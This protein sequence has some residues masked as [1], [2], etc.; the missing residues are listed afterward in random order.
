MIIVVLIEAFIE[1]IKDN[2]YAKKNN[3]YDKNIF[4]RSSD[5]YYSDFDCDI[6]LKKPKNYKEND[7][8][9]QGEQA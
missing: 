6:I 5:W 4:L 3:K 8:D 2:L 7:K 1:T 9:K